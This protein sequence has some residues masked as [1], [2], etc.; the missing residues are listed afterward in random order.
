[1][2]RMMMLQEFCSWCQIWIIEFASCPRL[3]RWRIAC[4]AS[5]HTDPGPA[6]RRMPSQQFGTFYSALFQA[7]YTFI[8]EPSNGLGRIASSAKP[9]CDGH[10][11]RHLLQRINLRTHNP[12]SQGEQQTT[13][14]V[15]QCQQCRCESISYSVMG[16]RYIALPGD[17]GRVPRCQV[18]GGTAVTLSFGRRLR[19]TRFRVSTPQPPTGQMVT[20]CVAPK[21][22]SA[23]DRRGAARPERAVLG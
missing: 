15:N 22:K 7:I 21:A 1:M 10:M 11:R 23:T 4:T 6:P 3:Q 2:A 13:K 14:G 18:F 5:F 19:D 9:R 12:A 17:I 16:D 20:N 8:L